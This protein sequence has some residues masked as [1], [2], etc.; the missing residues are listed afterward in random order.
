MTIIF[1]NASTIIFFSPHRGL[2][3]PHYITINRTSILHSQIFSLTK[4]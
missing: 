3:I 1:D 2:I 4:A